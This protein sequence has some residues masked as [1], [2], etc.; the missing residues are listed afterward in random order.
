MAKAN[1]ISV[2]TDKMDWWKRHDPELPHWSSACKSVLLLQPSSAAAEGVFSLLENSF[3]NRQ[4]IS[5]EDYMQ[6]SVMFQ[7]NYRKNED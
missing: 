3:K 5:L 4:T 7:Y 6:T 1:G 2:G